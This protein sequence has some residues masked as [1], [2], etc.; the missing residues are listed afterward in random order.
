MIAEGLPAPDFSLPDQ[1]GVMH[2]LSQYKGSWVVVYFY[3]KDDTPGCT[4]EACGFRDSYSSFRDK[5]IVVLGISK[6]TVSS[7]DQF[8]HKYSLPFPILSN[9]EKTVIGMY[10]AWGK[11]KFLGREF[12]GVLRI[13]V[14]V[15]P[16]GTVGKIFRSV[17]P[18][19]HAEEI[20]RE[21]ADMDE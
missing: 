2:A 17:T 1:N 6:D 16:D 9:P 8:S 4:K 5:K 7:H 11:K 15:R 21:I 13:T 10:G 19:T 3:P 14:L 20:L 12:E 18:S